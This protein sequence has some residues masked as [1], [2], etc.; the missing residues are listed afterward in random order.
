MELDFLKIENEFS[1]RYFL[2]QSTLD[3]A[4]MGL[5]ANLDLATSRALT[6]FRQYI[7]SD[8]AFSDLKFWPLCSEIA[9]LGL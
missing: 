4:T 3:F 2:L 8:L 5:A 9:T 7:N 6:D 1:V